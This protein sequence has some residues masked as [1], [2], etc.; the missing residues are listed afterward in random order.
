MLV[1]ER[2]K[3]AKK[4]VIGA[5]QTKK[6]IEKGEA[7]VVFVALDADSRVTDPVVKLALEKEIEI[8]KAATMKDLGRACGIEVG[9]AAVAIV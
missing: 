7:K 2:L 1:E 9:S 4:V 6:A 5:K 3:Q 8:V